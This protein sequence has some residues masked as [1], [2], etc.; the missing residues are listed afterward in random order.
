MGV[1]LDW[2]SLKNEGCLAQTLLIRCPA[3][4]KRKVRLDTTVW[5]LM[6]I[7][8]HPIGRAG[9]RISTKLVC[10][11]HRQSQALSRCT[12]LIFCTLG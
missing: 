1:R 9:G 8:T 10:S 2:V 5:F 7:P 11:D 12:V 4:Q 6:Q 3:Y